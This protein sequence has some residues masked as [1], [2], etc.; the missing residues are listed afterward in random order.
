MTAR[1][2]VESEVPSVSVSTNLPSLVRPR[3]TSTTVNNDADTV[4]VSSFL[5]FFAG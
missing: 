3:V 2:R 1:M 4:A 5:H